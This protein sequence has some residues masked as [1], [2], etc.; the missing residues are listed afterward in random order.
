MVI[1]VR[2]M[3]S[4]RAPSHNEQELGSG[5]DTKCNFGIDRMGI[6]QAQKHLMLGAMSGNELCSL[7]LGNKHVFGMDGLPLDIEQAYGVFFGHIT[8]VFNI[9]NYIMIAYPD[10]PVNLIYAH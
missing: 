2:F 10:E 6:I 8:D 5:Y 1:P 3:K 7:A 4:S 9:M